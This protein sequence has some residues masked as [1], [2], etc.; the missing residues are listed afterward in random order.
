VNIFRASLAVTATSLAMTSLE[1][2]SS[3]AM[4]NDKT[5]EKVMIETTTIQQRNKA[6]VRD[7]FDAWASGKG[8]PFE[9][10]AED[11]TWTITG[12]SAAS[13]TYVGREAFLRDV[14]RPFNARMQ[15][16]LKPV[17]H[18]IFADGDT[19][20]IFFDAS[21]VTRDGKPYANTY[22]W[23]LDMRD[24]KVVKA[25]AMFDSIEFND[26]WSRVQPTP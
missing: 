11:A 10:L 14:I 23:Y 19:V 25:T 24:G 5:Q 2:F 26:L 4:A 18:D 21:A 6:A 22:T 3:I 13:R 9:L 7:R 16:P 8:S 15:A 1:A 20:V 12:R 17:V